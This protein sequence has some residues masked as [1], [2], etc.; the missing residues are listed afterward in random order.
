MKF[1]GLW[2]SEGRRQIRNVPGRPWRDASRDFR[3]YI[4]ALTAQIDAIATG[5]DVS[6]LEQRVNT[7]IAAIDASRAAGE[8]LPHDLEELLARLVRKLKRARVKRAA[9]PYRLVKAARN[10]A[11][12][13]SLAFS[14]FV[15]LHIADQ[16][17]LFDQFVSFLVQQAN[18][19]MQSSWSPA[20][21]EQA[22]AQASRVP[23]E[24]PPPLTPN[25]AARAG[26]GAGS[27]LA[28]P[29]I[30]GT[31]PPGPDRSVVEDRLP[32]TIGNA[33]LRAAAVAGDPAAAYEVASRFGEGRGVP[34]SHQDEARWLE[35]AAAE[36]LAPAQ[37]R[38]G[39]L[40]EKGIGVEKDL[41]RARDLYLAAAQKGNAK[42]MHNL[43]V[44]YAEGISGTPDYQSAIGWFRNA[45]AHGVKDSQYNLGILYG[46]G[47]G[48]T[49][50]YAE[51]YKWFM[52]AANQGDG[53]AAIKRDEVAAYLDRQTR[54]AARLA[55]QSWS[56]EPQPDDAINVK[57]QAAWDAPTEAPRLPKSKSR[58]AGG[59]TRTADRRAS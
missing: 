36:G 1:T 33:A 47:I 10:L 3:R 55:A 30:T 46:R 5:Q 38:L 51:S 7:L 40:Y 58:P 23:L 52:L 49:Q 42:A 50:N 24:M 26:V 8:V 57:T 19:L 54:E 18:F 17:G 4:R 34:Q 32:A 43:A 9:K 11:A 41:P 53:D 15:G 48:V 2:N 6:A 45:A 31:L 29:E 28:A 56:P 35:R 16:A 12:G 13:L 22:V 20:E 27:P 39:G 44:L 21:P 37:F 59:D 25:P 14:L